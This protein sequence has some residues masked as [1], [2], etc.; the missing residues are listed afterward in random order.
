MYLQKD[1]FFHLFLLKIHILK[2]CL[3]HFK[4]MRFFWG[5][6]TFYYMYMFCKLCSP[7]TNLSKL[8]SKLFDSKVSLLFI[9]VKKEKK[10]CTLRRDEIL[11]EETCICCITLFSFK[12]KIFCL[13]NT[14]KG[15]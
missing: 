2:F 15:V 4:I 5:F 1:F 3:I 6:F 10:Y 11:S 14:I 9:F 13:E 7:I 8:L 12:E